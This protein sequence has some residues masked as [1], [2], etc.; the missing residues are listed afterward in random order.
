MAE[1]IR[2]ALARRRMSRERLAHEARISLSTLEKALIGSRPFTLAT[3]IRLEEALGV[4]L[5]SGPASG[6]QPTQAPDELGG[7]SRLAVSWLLGGYL[8]LRPS[9][10]EPGSI[11]AYRTEIVWD[12]P[13]GVLTF[14]E[15]QRLDAAYTQTGDVALSSR[16]GMTQLVT[17]F[18][19][20]HRVITLGRP[21]I[22]GTMYGILNT[23]Q[24][25]KGGQL[26][27]TAAAIAFLPL[28]RTSDPVFG[29]LRAGDGA[30]AAYRAHLDKIT[31]DGFVKLIG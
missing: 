1:R 30:F 8:T 10:E 28:K 14:Q 29:Q 15:S 26:I 19:G 18:H 31:A 5:R 7:Y 4:S 9:F 21:A 6:P 11:F 25:A 24:A 16:T 22:D 13:R 2:E 23:L 27:P 3:L 20:E 17:N 12:D